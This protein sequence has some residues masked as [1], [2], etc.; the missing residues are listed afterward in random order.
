MDG[1]PQ[2]LF[3]PTAPRHDVPK[4]PP[5][6]VPLAN[7]RGFRIGFG[8]VVIMLAALVLVPRVISYAAEDAIVQ[9]HTAMLQT[10]IEGTVG[11]VNARPGQTITRGAALVSIANPRIDHSFLNKLLTERN[12]LQRRVDNLA[13]QAQGLMD[14][15]D[16]LAERKTAVSKGA[17]SLLDKEIAARRAE[18]AAVRARLRASELHLVR[19]T[20]LHKK[21][22]ASSRELEVARAERDTLQAQ[23]AQLEARIDAL[24]EQRA[25]AVKGVFMADGRFGAPYSEIR[26]DEIAITLL[27]LHSRQGQEQTRIE[28][29]ER[30]IVAEKM[31][32]E[33]TATAQITAPF[34]G[35]VWKIL[36]PVGSE[37]VIGAEVAQVVDCNS[38]FLEILVSESRFG[39]ISIGEKIRYR[40]VGTSSFRSGRV[41]ALRGGNVHSNDRSLAA[42][43]ASSHSRGFRVWAEL[44]PADRHGSGEAFCNVGRR[45]DVRFKRDFDLLASI[46]GLWSAL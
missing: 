16:Q 30:Q 32:L 31:R 43:L 46:R 18:R 25:Q 45:V 36:T 44:D 42:D 34:D 26:Q 5:T 38:P 8:L 9:S 6:H 27:D 10:P 11:K 29:I 41:T 20:Q 15:R 39:R 19:Q 1:L 28:Q 7:R 40:F 12:Y 24:R 2:T 14:L 21:G 33:R 23:R 13:Q 35:V 3:E 4:G 37:V 22:L 17:A